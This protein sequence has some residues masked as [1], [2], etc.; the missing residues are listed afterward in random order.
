MEKIKR[1]VSKNQR[2][3]KNRQN[4]TWIGV[5][6]MMIMFLSVLGFALQYNPDDNSQ[7]N[8]DF[9]TYNGFKFVHSNGFWILDNFVFSYNPSEVPDIGSGLRDATY[10]AEQPLYIFSENEESTIEVIMNLRQIVQRYQEACPAENVLNESVQ[11]LEDVP[12]KSCSENFI[13][14]R[15]GMNNSIFQ[16]EGCVYI[17]GPKE[18]LLKLTD[19]FLFKILTIK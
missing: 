12:F 18:E 14:I 8:E 17:T 7:N 19:Q 3:K 6:L 16:E 1:L 15:E 11:C 2:K 5:L 9:L 10:Y 13:I 4:Q